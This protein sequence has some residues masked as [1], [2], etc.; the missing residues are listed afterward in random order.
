MH[1]AA[2]A[3][4]AGA[5][6]TPGER[7][8]G[9]VVEKGLLVAIVLAMILLPTLESLVRR[10][11]G[12]GIPGSMPFILSRLLAVRGHG[13]LPAPD[14]PLFTHGHT[15]LFAWPGSV[16]LA[17]AFLLGAPVFVV[18]AGFALLLFFTAGTPVAAVPG[19]TFRLVVQ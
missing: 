5:H 17:V 16:L 11:F 18:M 3:L 15:G 6:A 1:D 19:E 12:T 10:F 14:G 4:P 8:G 2:A 13:F 7:P 9:T